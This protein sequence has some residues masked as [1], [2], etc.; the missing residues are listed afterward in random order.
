MAENQTVAAEAEQKSVQQPA[1]SREW[2]LLE[3]VRREI[4]RLFEDFHLGSWR[5]P[6][7]R[8]AGELAPLWQS[9]TQWGAAPAVDI[10]EKE[11]GYEIT[12]EL[13]GMDL[14]NIGVK[15]SKGAL[16]IKGEK[17]EE[18]EREGKDYFVSERRWGSFQRSFRVPEG[19]DEDKIEASFSNGVL[20]IVLPKTAEAKKAEK[21]IAIKTP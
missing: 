3:S 14:S 20:T 18:K 2:H 15:F 8:G 4:D 13:P 9:E 17:K 19:I 7:A 6:F 16:T 11:H 1:T 10:V 12:A 21:T 5:L